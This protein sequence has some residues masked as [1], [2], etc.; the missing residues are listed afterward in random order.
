MPNDVTMFV[1]SGMSIAMGNADDEV[2]S[3]AKFTTDSNE[4]EGFA[5]AIRRFIL[6][7]SGS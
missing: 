2:K 6:D 5:K 7:G 1:R 4:N 3:Q